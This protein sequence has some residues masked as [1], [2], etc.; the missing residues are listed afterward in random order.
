YNVVSHVEKPMLFQCLVMEQLG[1]S[2]ASNLQ[3]DDHLS[4]SLS[5]FLSLSLSLSLSVSHT[6]THT[7]KHTHTH[8][9]T[10]RHYGC[11]SVMCDG[12]KGAVQEF[13]LIFDFKPCF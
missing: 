2:N 13:W 8:T 12:G 7:H 5:L 6:H 3:D 10:H 1:T 11:N 4:L 9:Q